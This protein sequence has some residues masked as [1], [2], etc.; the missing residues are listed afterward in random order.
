MNLERG[1]GQA[2]R[3]VRTKVINVLNLLHGH[4]SNLGEGEVRGGKRSRSFTLSWRNSICFV[5]S[6]LKPTDLVSLRFEYLIHI[7]ASFIDS[8]ALMMGKGVTEAAAR[9]QYINQTG[10]SI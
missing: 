3:D 5:M 6:F 2:A 9:K 7:C 8:K 4:C 10:V 1:L